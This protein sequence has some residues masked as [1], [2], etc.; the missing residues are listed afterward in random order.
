M[1]FI[2][3][4][5][6]VL[7]LLLAGFV[8]AQAPTN[9]TV[10]LNLAEAQ[11]YALKNNIG[12]RNSA[13][14]LE[15]AKKKI[16]ETTAIGLPQINAQANY[17]HIFKVPEMSFGG[18]TYLATGLPSGTVIT[19]DDINNGN[20]YMGYKA[21]D[22]IKLG[23]KDN[24][25][26]DFTVSQLLF[27]GEYIVGLQAS[28]VFYLMSEQN[29]EK[30]EL[31]LK[32]AIANSYAM[33]LVFEQTRSVLQQSLINTQKTLNDMKA[34]YAQG[35]IENTDVD[36]IE[37]VSL[38]LANGLSSLDR[39]IDATYDLL[40]YQL[41]MPFN[42]KLVLTDNL[43]NMA[44]SIQLEDIM[45]NEFDISKN[46]DYQILENNEVIGD[47]N[48][49]REMSTYLPNI[50]AVYL[51]NEKLFKPDLDFS[52]RDI[53]QI[54][55]NV[56][57]FSSFQRHV[58]VQQRRI[59]LQKIVNT[60]NDVANGLQLQY[61]NTKNEL[62]TAY[63]KYNNDRKNIELTKRIYDKTL[64]KFNE[65]LASSRDITDNLNQYL[66]SQSNMY[67]SILAVISAKNKL[68]KLNN[69]L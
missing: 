24:V 31:N 14:D 53:I 37:L 36:Q 64:I 41:G 23:V 50:A 10:F 55:M 22:P 46:L 66:T 34:M 35:L 60:K 61:I 48:L 68:Q 13:L 25:T 45:S 54:S 1:K 30:T 39:Q 56:P 16:W 27:S 29:K 52:P 26:V 69:T 58:K 42:E 17:Q 20:V 19:S 44:T 15:I 11:Q 33:A 3:I 38:T 43:E 40:K 4:Q 21:L 12:T 28:K 2:F 32:E 5:N 51:H 8:Q 9:D 59:E 67:N 18:I 6:L 7:G 63:E 49:K 62:T 57:I 65:G 47:L